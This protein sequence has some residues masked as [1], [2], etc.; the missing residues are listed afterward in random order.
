MLFRSFSTA[1]PLNA[2][3]QIRYNAYLGTVNDASAITY[4]QGGTGAS[5]RTVENKLQESVSVEDFGAVGDG[6]TD[7]TAAINNAASAVGTGYIKFNNKTYLINS[8][9]SLGNIESN[10]ATIKVKDS[11][12]MT[13]DYIITLS[14]GSIQKGKLTLDGN[15]SNNSGFTPKYGFY[16]NNHDYDIDHLKVINFWNTGVRGENVAR[17]NFN[18]LE[19]DT[20]S[21]CAYLN[22]REDTGYINRLI[23]K[24]SVADT[25]GANP[26]AFDIFSLENGVVNSVVIDS[27]DGTAVAS[28]T[29]YSGL[30]VQGMN[31]SV[32]NNIDIRGYNSTV[33]VPL[34]ISILS[35]TNT[36]YSN[37]HIEGWGGQGHIE[38]AGCQDCVFEKGTVTSAYKE[39]V[40]ITSDAEAFSC[41]GIAFVNHGVK[42][43]WAVVGRHNTVSNGNIVRDFTFTNMGVAIA[44]SGR[45]N[46]YINV[47]SFGALRSGYL[48]EGVNDNY[49]FWGSLENEG[50]ALLD[51]CT[52]NYSGRSGIRASSNIRMT[53]CKTW[54][55]GV[56]SQTG[57]EGVPTLDYRAGV[58]HD[59]D[60]LDVVIEHHDGRDMAST[61]A[62]TQVLSI[63]SQQSFTTSTVLEAYH[64][65]GA[66]E[67]QAG[68]IITIVDGA[69]SGADDL[70]VRVE[71]NSEGWDKLY[72]R[73]VTP[74]SGTTSGS[75]YSITGTFSGTAGTK[76]FT[77]AGG[78]L[79][80]EITGKMFIYVAPHTYTVNRV[81]SDTELEVAEDLSTTYSSVSASKFVNDITG[82][83]T[84]SRCYTG[85]NVRIRG[86]RWEGVGETDKVAWNET[87]SEVMMLGEEQ[88]VTATSVTA[89]GSLAVTLPYDI[90]HAA[91]SGDKTKLIATCIGGA[92]AACSVSRSGQQEVT[93]YNG[94]ATL[95]RTFDV[96][97]VY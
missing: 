57:F 19:S 45:N 72:L 22:F 48:S 36:T 92:P 69:N 3:I 16:L 75:S 85:G 2:D 62:G 86:M 97:V 60:N 77:V 31:D 12:S 32:I 44:D 88:Y 55:N 84:Q 93:V 14:A 71:K 76:T 37:I 33:L 58:R 35:S 20:C 94:H 4:N 17:S 63:Q 78:S 82:V 49:Y 11:S 7:D 38:A 74:T 24:N 80:T 53:N 15:K 9:L 5:S 79:K 66:H 25:T 96:K 64:K 42:D 23:A 56:A 81:V 54:G 67:F 21:S 51:N 13:G 43:D 1:P 50:Y 30:T 26:H 87:S 70:V 89:S 65:E 28:S 83:Q 52:F 41:Y 95:S 46:K 91:G 8:P 47:K 10:D 6:V 68:Q 29:W 90:P 18:I 73:P 40:A 27:A 59:G 61:F 34:A 39:G